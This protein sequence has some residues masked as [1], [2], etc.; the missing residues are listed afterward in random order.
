MQERANPEYDASKAKRAG[1][2]RDEFEQVRQGRSFEKTYIR[3][4]LKEAREQMI[5]DPTLKLAEAMKQRGISIE[6]AKDGDLKFRREGSK[7]SFKGSTIGEQ[8]GRSA[9]EAAIREGRSA[10]ARQLSGGRGLAD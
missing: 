10:T 9:L 5:A 3:R 8:Y 4:S 6:V 7:L 1:I 2:S